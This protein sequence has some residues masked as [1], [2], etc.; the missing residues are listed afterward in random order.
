MTGNAYQVVD[1]RAAVCN[2]LTECGNVTIS[3]IFGERRR[4][5]NGRCNGFIILHCSS[6]Y[7][8]S[9]FRTSKMR[10]K[11]NEICWITRQLSLIPQN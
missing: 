7:E 4:S 1:G 6:S 8:R 5:V 3:W 9:R 11:K 10:S 2:Q